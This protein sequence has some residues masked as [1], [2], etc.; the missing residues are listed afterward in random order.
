MLEPLV[1]PKLSALNPMTLYVRSVQWFVMFRSTYNAFAEL[2]LMLKPGA[3]WDLCGT[4]SPPDIVI[5]GS[6]CQV[7]LE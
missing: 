3:V 7:Y 6:G 1:I 5:V 4:K 2:V